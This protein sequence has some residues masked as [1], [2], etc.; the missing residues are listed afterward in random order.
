MEHYLKKKIIFLKT[1]D[2]NS[3]YILDDFLFFYFCVCYSHKNCY[4]KKQ[5]FV[6]PFSPKNGQD[7][8]VGLG[9]HKINEHDGPNQ[10]FAKGNWIIHEHYLDYNLHNDIALIHLDTPVSINSDV[11]A[12]GIA[13][14]E[15]NKGLELLVSGWGNRDRKF[16]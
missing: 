3:W 5:C 6:L 7:A 11:Q 10:K 15:P 9:Y 12:I 1:C 13:S 16:I 4:Y 14:S 2:C 8:W